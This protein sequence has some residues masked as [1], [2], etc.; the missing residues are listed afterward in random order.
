MVENAAAVVTVVVITAVS[1]A[2]AVTAAVSVAAAAVTVV[3]SVVPVLAITVICAR[4]PADSLLSVSVNAV[5]VPIIP[6]VPVVPAVTFGAADVTQNA[7]RDL[8]VP[9]LKIPGVE[10]KFCSHKKQKQK[11]Q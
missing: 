5:V 3:A 2:A 6:V 9:L 4:V 10:Q 11:N 1:V 8:G 7:I